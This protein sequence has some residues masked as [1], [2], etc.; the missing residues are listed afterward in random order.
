M[1]TKIEVDINNIKVEKGYFSFDY[2]VIIN[3]KVIEE[4]TYDNSHSWND[5]KAF[6]KLLK[7]GYAVSLAIQWVL[8]SENN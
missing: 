3:D 8:R 4:N 2:I 5:K 7:D 1:K 6:K